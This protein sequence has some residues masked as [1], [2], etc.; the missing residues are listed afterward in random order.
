M[1]EDYYSRKYVLFQL[2]EGCKDREIAFLGNSMAFRGY[3]AKCIFDIE[4]GLKVINSA[5]NRPNS[6]VSVAKFKNIPVFT[7][8]PKKRR[9]ETSEWFRNNS[10][11]IAG[12]DLFFDF[13]KSASDSWEDLIK[14]VKTLKEYLDDY[15]VSYQ[16]LFSGNKGFQII[17]NGIFLKIEKIENGNVYPH[18]T[19]VEKIKETL[20]LKFLDLSNNGEKSKLRKLPYSLVIPNMKNLSVEDIENLTE[21]EINVCL[22][23]SDEQFNNFNLLDMKLTNVLK[24][25]TIMRR[26]NLERFSELSEEEKRGNVEEF[27]KIFN[28]K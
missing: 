18:K 1:T 28:L 22:P 2:L 6:Y 4:N 13:D 3:K 17:I 24:K 7:F 23:L 27:I 8:N 20:D 12:F 11:E 15:K 14:E 9:L 21:D 5:K 10:N 25:V 16:L 19:I 26:G